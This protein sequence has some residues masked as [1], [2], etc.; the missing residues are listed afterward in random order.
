V[1]PE[2]PITHDAESRENGLYMSLGT[3]RE[4]G[5]YI[6]PRSCV[7]NTKHE[8]VGGSA[9]ASKTQKHRQVGGCK[10]AAVPFPGLPRGKKM[11]PCGCYGGCL[12]GSGPYKLHH[13]HQDHRLLP[14]RHT[15]RGSG[16]VAAHAHVDASRRRPRSTRPVCTE[17]GNM[18]SRCRHESRVPPTAFS[19]YSAGRFGSLAE[20]WA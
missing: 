15:P 18:P 6:S 16:A 3:C 5:L 8:Q 9:D 19:L 17:G 12:N 4:H 11:R 1:R 2:S 10:T 13:H 14:H 7:Q 20:L